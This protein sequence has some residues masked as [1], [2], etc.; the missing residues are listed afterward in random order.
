VGKHT[1]SAYLVAHISSTAPR[2][3]VRVAIYSE[4]PVS[5]M[6]LHEPQA[7]LLKADA[8]TYGQARETILQR[9][10]QPAWT[11]LKDIPNRSF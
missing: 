1:S 10:R 6:N 4:F 3:I 7:A 2:T 9:I 5:T 8:A 11:W